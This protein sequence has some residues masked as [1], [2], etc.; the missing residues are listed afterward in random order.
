M[1]NVNATGELPLEKLLGKHICLN[2][3]TFESGDKF[4][5]LCHFLLSGKL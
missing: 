3:Y 1:W 4:T 5:G 2:N